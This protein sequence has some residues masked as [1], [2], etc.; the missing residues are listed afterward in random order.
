MKRL[1]RF[2]E[3]RL[4]GKWARSARWEELK[5]HENG[6]DNKKVGPADWSGEML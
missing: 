4:E 2:A 5:P 3:R 1:L 6:N